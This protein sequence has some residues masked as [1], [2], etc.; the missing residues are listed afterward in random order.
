MAQHGTIEAVMSRH[1]FS[2][3]ADAHATSAWM[4]L[5]QLG[6][7]HLAVRQGE[8]IFGVVT[9]RDLDR[10][11]AQGRD[12]SHTSAVR[13]ADVCSRDVYVVEPEAPLADV[14]VHMANTQ[15]DVVLVA[16]KGHLTGIFTFSDACRRYAELLQTDIAPIKKRR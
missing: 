4:M 16:R 14:L 6:I 7:H 1:P 9:D 13:V 12:F 10:A 5:N 11:Q 8:N 3:E 2:I 15:R